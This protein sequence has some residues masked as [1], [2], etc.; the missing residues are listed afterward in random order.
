MD[1]P[2]HCVTQGATIDTFTPETLISPCVVIDV[3]A[4]TH[5]AF[6]LSV[7][8]IRAFETL[9]G[10]IAEKSFVIIHTGWCRLWKNRD[11]YRNEGKFPSVSQEAAL[12]LL[13]KNMVGLG[14]DTLSPDRADSG[15]PVHQCLLGH[16]KYLVENVMQANCLPPIGSFIVTMPM[17]IA[18]ATE[19]PVRLVGL[20]PKKDHFA[21]QQLIQL[22]ASV[23]NFGFDWPDIP[24]IIQQAQSECVEIEEAVDKH[25]SS[26]RLQEEI[27]DLLHTAISLCLFAGFSVEETLSNVVKKFGGRMDKVRTLTTQQGLS[28]LKGQSFEFMLNLW[29]K[30]K[31]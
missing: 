22:E 27:G 19:A 11:N 13:T 29:N 1:A 16:G 17:K 14:I 25:E 31:Q 4:K 20:I 18:Q 30:A 5:A 2:A 12:Y 7:D 15:Y 9:H 23:R 26:E 6:E 21:L 24:T 10:A 28:T 3:S 8:D